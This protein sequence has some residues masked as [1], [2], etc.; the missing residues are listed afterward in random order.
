MI[1]FIIG[2][3][4]QGKLEYVLDNNNLTKEDV[5]NCEECDYNNI[6]KK[7]L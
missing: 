2:G 7:I 4:S 6:D 3:T 1:E 5:C